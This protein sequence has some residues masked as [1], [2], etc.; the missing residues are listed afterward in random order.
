MTRITTASA[1]AA[2]LL[3]GAAGAAQAADNTGQRRDG[4]SVGQRAKHAA[5]RVGDAT[6]NT[7][8]RAKNA[9][10]NGRQDDTQ[11][12]GAGADTMADGSR[13]TMGNRGD[14]AR[15]QRMDE[16]YARW[17]AGQGSTRR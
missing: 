17:Q 7:W 14:S 1:L 6:R 2:A 10:K 3:L 9:V 4:P 8:H 12:M 15:Q 16:A 5:N 13:A 11:R